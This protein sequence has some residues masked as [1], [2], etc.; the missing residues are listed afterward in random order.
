MHEAARLA[1]RRVS[2]PPASKRLDIEN[3]ETAP[4]RGMKILL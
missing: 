4:N 3:S 1:T 2:L